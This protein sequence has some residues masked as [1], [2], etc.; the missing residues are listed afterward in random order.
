MAGAA[1]RRPRRRVVFKTEGA[2]GGG[3][4]YSIKPK[5]LAIVGSVS[6]AGNQDAYKI[7]EEVLDRYAPELVISGGA[8]GI[9]SMA[10]ERARAWGIE[11]WEFLPA[12]PRWED[13]YKPRNLEIARECD[14]LVRI[15]AR[16]SRT[17]GSGWTRDRAAEMGKPTEE[18]LI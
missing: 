4:I 18:F 10:A 17:Y 11:V 13:G 3:V 16:G 5:R 6:L 14:A 9:D 7:I 2:R 8:K 15:A 1:R 12:F